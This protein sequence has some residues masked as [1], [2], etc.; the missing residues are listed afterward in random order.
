MFPMHIQLCTRT[1]LLWVVCIVIQY[2]QLFIYYC[3]CFL[4]GQPAAK[5]KCLFNCRWY[6]QVNYR[7]INYSN[8]VPIGSLLASASDSDGESN[9]LKMSNNNLLPAE[10]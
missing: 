3:G 1:I 7:P 8:S 6:L 2:I 10:N 4:N 9:E 5:Y